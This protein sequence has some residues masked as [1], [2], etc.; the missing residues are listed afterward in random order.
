MFP[1]F[2]SVRSLFVVFCLLSLWLFYC[3]CFCFVSL[4]DRWGRSGKAWDW[5]PQI[6]TK[7]CEFREYWSFSTQYSSIQ[8]YVFQIVLSNIHWTVGPHT[9]MCKICVQLIKSLWNT[10]EPVQAQ[11][12]PTWSLR[13]MLK[14][15][16]AL[17]DYPL[18]PTFPLPVMNPCKPCSKLLRSHWSNRYILSR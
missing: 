7:K 9:K 1:R 13:A 2:C 12:F 4:I 11:D 10:W 5:F 17:L 6:K 3:L 14:H 18:P 16:F 8:A 15:V